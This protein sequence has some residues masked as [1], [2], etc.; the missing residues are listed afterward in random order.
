MANTTNVPE[1]NKINKTLIAAVIGWSII[2][3]AV[4]L[5]A[6][7]YAGVQYHSGQEA[8]KKAAVQDALKAVHATQV[9]E[10]SPKN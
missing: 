4:L 9:A 7:F 8:S 3:G 10:A 1:S 6:G 2:A 5:G